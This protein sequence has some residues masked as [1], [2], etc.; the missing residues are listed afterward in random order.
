MD[1]D[2]ARLGH[3][4]LLE[5]RIDEL[6]H[7]LPYPIAGRSPILHRRSLL[8]HRGIGLLIIPALVAF[9]GAAVLVWR[10]RP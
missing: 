5:A 6:A 10:E 1:K 4:R 3:Y 2:D 9:A 7:W 8:V